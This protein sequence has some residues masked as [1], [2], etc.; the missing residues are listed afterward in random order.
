R[1]PLR[2]PVGGSVLRLFGS[3]GRKLDVGR[4]ASTVGCR[5][6]EHLDIKKIIAK[7]PTGYAEDAAGMDG[8]QLRREIIRAET[9]LPGVEKELR[10]DQKLQGAREVLKDLVGA[11]NE[12][13]RAQRAKISYSLHLLDERGELGIG[14]AP[15]G[16]SRV[17]GSASRKTRAA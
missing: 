1:N 15:E 17:R 16:L 6:Y 5:R 2:V 11:Y 8:D 9:A 12:A 3:F 14:E 4:G 13:R 7:L 10:A